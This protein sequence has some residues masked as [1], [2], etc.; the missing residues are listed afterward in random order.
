[1][2]II[3]FRA[4]KNFAGLAGL[5]EMCGAK[6]RDLGGGGGGISNLCLCL[7]FYVRRSSLRTGSCRD[8]HAVLSAVAI[9]PP[10]PILFRETVCIGMQI[11]LISVNDFTM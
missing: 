2:Q 1:M 5:I 10:G 11:R 7:Y 6:R 9:R 8:D 4:T 3:R